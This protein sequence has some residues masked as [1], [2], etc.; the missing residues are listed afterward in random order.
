MP[1]MPQREIGVEKK[2][3]MHTEQTEMSLSS[4]LPLGSDRRA[5][6]GEERRR[7]DFGDGAVCPASWR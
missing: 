1:R 5:P 7:L 6:G 3:Q 4:F 2:S